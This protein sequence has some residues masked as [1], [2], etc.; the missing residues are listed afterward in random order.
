MTHSEHQRR[1]REI[2]KYIIELREEYEGIRES[3]SDRDHALFVGYGP[4][5]N[6]KLV[7]V[8]IVE[9]GESGST[10]AAPI[11]QKIIDEYLKEDL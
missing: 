11:A 2:S 7:M 1:V 8:V 9:N 4:I 3:V 10:V 5:K 6:P